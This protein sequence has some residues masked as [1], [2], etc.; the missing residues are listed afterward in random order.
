MDNRKK[1]TKEFKLEAVRLTNQP[2]ITVRQVAEDLG[3]H[4]SLV[5]RWRQA[6][7]VDKDQAFPGNGRLKPDDEE[8]RRPAK[9]VPH[10]VFGSVGVSTN[11]LPRHPCKNGDSGDLDFAGV[12][13]F[14]PEP[15]PPG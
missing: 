5:H 11:S 13:G 2:G 10:D 9:T 4:E 6:F 15:V 3:C 7:L 1:Y 12:S 14:R 8:I